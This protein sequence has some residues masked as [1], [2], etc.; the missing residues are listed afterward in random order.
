MNKTRTIGVL[1]LVMGLGVGAVILNNSNAQTIVTEET[2]VSNEVVKPSVET[3]EPAG[4]VYTVYT[5]TASSS[6]RPMVASAQFTSNQ[7]MQDYIAS[8]D[9]NTSYTIDNVTIVK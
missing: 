8:L 2:A 3:V 5:T 9:S 6:G 7:D 4:V 1:C